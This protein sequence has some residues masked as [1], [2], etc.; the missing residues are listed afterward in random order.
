M[1]LQQMVTVLSVFRKA[2][3][4]ICLVRCKMMRERTRVA[5]DVEKIE[6]SYIKKLKIEWPSESLLEIYPKERKSRSWRDSASPVFRASLFIV[7]EIREQPT[8]LSTDEWI[9]KM[10]SMLIVGY[11]STLKKR[12]I[13]QSV[14]TG[15]NL[16][17]VMLSELDHHRR[18]NTAWFY[19]YRKNLV[20]FTELKSRITVVMGRGGELGSYSPMGM[21][22]QLFEMNKL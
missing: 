11:Y 6:A 12:K 18:T 16:E 8:W 7:A 13:L 17:D 1:A 20:K 10:C 5:E 19:L 14:R 22:F 4:S 15:M 2:Q 3:P 21:K 9:K